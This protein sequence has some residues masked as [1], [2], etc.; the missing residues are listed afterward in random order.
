MMLQVESWVEAVNVLAKRMRDYER[1]I[2]ELR[3][4][5]EK[6]REALKNSETIPAP[7]MCD[8]E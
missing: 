7:A 3:Y 2:Y 4:E 6:L 1:T 5:N 8:E